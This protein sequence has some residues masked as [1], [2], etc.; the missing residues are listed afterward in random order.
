MTAVE[1]AESSKMQ[2]AQH[3]VD[4]ATRELMLVARD[5]RTSAQPDDKWTRAVEHA[6]AAAEHLR[7]VRSEIDE[8]LA[9][10]RPTLRLPPRG[11]HFVIDRLAP[12]HVTNI[13]NVLGPRRL[14][15]ARSRVPSVRVLA[16]A[17]A[18]EL[19]GAVSE[20][21]ADALEQQLFGDLDAFVRG[22]EDRTFVSHQ[23][24]TDLHA[25]RRTATK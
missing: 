9:V 15:L 6:R 14:L 16:S 3:A 12:G 8:L 1:K 19:F 22:A 7:D 13:H 17:M 11:P 24:I 21:D 23:R 5:E 18:A 10:P 4:D 2:L 20:G 25:A